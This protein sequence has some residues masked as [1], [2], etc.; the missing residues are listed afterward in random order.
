VCARRAKPRKRLSK[1]VEKSI[2]TKSARRCALCYGMKGDLDEKRGQIA[3]I[4]GDRSNNASRNLAFMCLEHHSEFDSR[5]SQHKNYT[6]GEVR[7]YLRMLYRAVDR[8]E[9]LVPG[10]T[11]RFSGIQAD[12][13]TL[14]SLLDLMS[15]TG[16]IDFLRENNFAGWS[17]EWNR[18]EGIERFIMRKG[19]EHEFIDSE[20][21][22]LR[23]S[24][25]DSCKV[26]IGLLARYTHPVG[27]GNR[28]SIPEDWE[29]DLPEQ[30]EKAVSEVHGAAENVCNSYDV[31]VRRARKKILS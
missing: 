1:V 30:F 9:H 12:R 15:K 5:T 10:V 20:L 13:E 14:N 7:G 8:N 6:A 4:D 24:F 3:H 18:L 16:T 26:I 22:A 19:P 21:E 29:I 31:L 25:Y 11:H 2:L 23:K 17:F 27:S 28:Q